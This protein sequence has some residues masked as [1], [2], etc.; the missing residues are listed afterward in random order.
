MDFV[1]NLLLTS[2]PNLTKAQVAVFVAGLLNSDMDLNTFKLHLR[3]FL[4]TL[5]E[6]STED[7]ADLFLEENL[8]KK[9]ADEDKARQAQL[10]VPGLVNP[11]DLPED[12]MA[13]L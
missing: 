8:A 3:D 2:F 9:Q 4:V 12:D 10:A 11:H 13:D 1:G 5:K 6:F 7:N